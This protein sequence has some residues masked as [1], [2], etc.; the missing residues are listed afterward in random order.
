[1]PSARAAAMAGAMCNF[2]A[3]QA[4]LACVRVQAR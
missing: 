1:M 4:A 3:K 2:V